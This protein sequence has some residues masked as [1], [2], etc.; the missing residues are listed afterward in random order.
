MSRR[1]ILTTLID[2]LEAETGIESG[3][4]S[5]DADLAQLGLDSLDMVRLSAQVERRLDVTIKTE[6]LFYLR[7][8]DDIVTLLVTKLG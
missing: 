3:G 4:V 8:V 1:E 6:E 5:P 7:T 2:M